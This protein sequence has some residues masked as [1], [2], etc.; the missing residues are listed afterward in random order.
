MQLILFLSIWATSLLGI[1]LFFFL[2]HR[3][4]KKGTPSLQSR[5]EYGGLRTLFF[6][7]VIVLEESLIH[8][9][10]KIY[11]E[12]K[13]YSISD[14]K[15]FVREQIPFAFLKQKL[16]RFSYFKKEKE[17]EEASHFLRSMREHKENYRKNGD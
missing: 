6:E 8:Y 9:A 12:M 3:G 7:S 16:S 11:D 10:K 13:E 1:V 15:E 2:A 4:V 5:K 14:I 17:R